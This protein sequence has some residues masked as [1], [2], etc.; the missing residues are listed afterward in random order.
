[1]VVYIEYVL[2]NNFFIDYMILNAAFILTGARYKKGSLILASILGAVFALIFPLVDGV[3]VI[4]FLIK[5]ASG[6]LVVL[7]PAKYRNFREYF[8]NAAVFFCYTFLIGGVIIGVFNI[9]NLD[10]SIEP[11]SALICLPVYVALKFFGS[12]VNHIYRRKDIAANIVDI[13]LT[14]NK[15]QVLCKGFFDT[16]N[17]VYHNN[18]PVI[19]CSKRF[20]FANFVE[21]LADS[22]FEK[23][24]VQ[25][26]N[27]KSDNLSVKVDELKIYIKDKQ[28]TFNNVT[29]MI[30]KYSVGDGYD[31][32][33]HPALYKESGDEKVD[34]KAKKVS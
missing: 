15:K 4:S 16:G 24:S 21:R 34:F 1:M 23:I 9:F 22:R 11:F 7:I 6:L 30:S 29:L 20:F 26:V 27:G 25:T 31:V 17:G 33:L 32:I 2:I 13:S 14:V 19:V 3:K 18:L 8:I 5:I 12:V 28:N 10:Y